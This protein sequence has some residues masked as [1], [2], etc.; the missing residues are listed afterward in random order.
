MSVVNISTDSQTLG[1]KNVGNVGRAS[2]TTIL[3]LYC[4]SD[5]KE[6]TYHLP[7]TSG[8]TATERKKQ[9]KDYFI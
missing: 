6:R 9:G 1:E 3:Q 4:R 5:R 2:N 7:Y 8:R